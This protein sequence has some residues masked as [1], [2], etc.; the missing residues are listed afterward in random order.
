MVSYKPNS[1]STALELAELGGEIWKRGD[2]DKEN[3]VFGLCNVGLISYR[4]ENDSETSRCHF[5]M[6]LEISEQLG[7]KFAIGRA[8]HGLAELFFHERDLDQALAYFTKLSELGSSANYKLLV[9]HAERR[10]AEIKVQK[11]QNI[12]HND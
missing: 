10:I 11:Q 6:A 8:Y 12:N 9:D 2:Y 4:I 3:I 7:F 5:Q 1:E